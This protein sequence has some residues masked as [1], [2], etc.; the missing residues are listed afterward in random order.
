MD[1]ACDSVNTIFHGLEKLSE[2]FQSTKNRSMIETIVKLTFR[3]A[4]QSL[5]VL[6]EL[7]ELNFFHQLNKNVSPTFENYKNAL[8]SIFCIYNQKENFPRVTYK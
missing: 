7:G 6:T 3:K 5:V 1:Q 2:T 4:A 8:Y